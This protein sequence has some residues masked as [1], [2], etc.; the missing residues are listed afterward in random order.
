MIDQTVG[1]AVCG[2]FCTHAKAM[3]ALEQ[4][5]ARF[6]TVIPIVSECTAATD[7][8]FGPAHELM[9][10]MER[11]C[12]RR[13]ISSIREA[14]PIG[15]KKLLDLLIIAPCT[16]NTLGKLACGI[17]DTA[18]TMAAKAHLR[19][20]RPLLIAPSTNDG[21]T[22]SA[23][24]LGALLSRKYI[25]F[26]PFGQDD[27]VKKP[28]SLVADFSLVA[29]AAQAALEGRQLQPLLRVV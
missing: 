26:V 15:P 29:D 27:P 19:N 6:S 24:N 18:V 11:I 14:E 25:Y 28:T 8:R 3:E 7:T 4:V 9:R 5:K 2:S 21:L 22:A 10:E 1:F 23:P 16:G 13:V 17:T 20:Q 12:D